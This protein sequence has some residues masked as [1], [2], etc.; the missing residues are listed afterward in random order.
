MG[1][2]VA[3]VGMASVVGDTGALLDSIVGASEDSFA[4]VVGTH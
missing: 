4:G 3:V 1:G 2:A